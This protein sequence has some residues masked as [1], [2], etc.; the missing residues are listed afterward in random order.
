MGGYE[1]GWCFNED[2][3]QVLQIPAEIRHGVMDGR[4]RPTKN[5]WVNSKKLHTDIH[6]LFHMSILSG[7]GPLSLYWWFMK[8]T[9]GQHL[10]D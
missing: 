10:I 5:N 4:A 6:T 8:E 7:Q 1:Q 2:L 9:A 3:K